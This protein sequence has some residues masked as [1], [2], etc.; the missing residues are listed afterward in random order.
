MSQKTKIL[1]ETYTTML[2]QQPELLKIGKFSNGRGLG[3]YYEEYTN[4]GFSML[5]TISLFLKTI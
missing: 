4:G 1:S 2:P 3:H 5:P